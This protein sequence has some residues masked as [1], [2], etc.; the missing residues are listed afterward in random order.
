MSPSRTPTA[1]RSTTSRWSSPRRARRARRRQRRRQVDAPPARGRVA[2]PHERRRP[3][4]RLRGGFARRPALAVV[5]LRPTVA[6]RRPHRERAHRVRVAPARRTGASRIGRRAA[7]SA[8]PHAPGRRPA[9]PLQPRVAPEDRVRARAGAAV[10]GAP[11]RRTVRRPRP[12][13]PGRPRRVADRGG[14]RRVCGDGR[15]APARLPRRATR[16]VALRDGA[17]AYR[18]PVDRA[19]IDPLLD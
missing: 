10:L 7:R 16:C 9:R 4:R 2:R 19:V 17:V 6:V 12:R 11:R 14:R 13:R 5:H 15:D 1:S 8:Q 3:R 18:G